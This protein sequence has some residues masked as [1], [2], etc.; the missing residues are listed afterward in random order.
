[1]MYLTE[2]SLKRVIWNQYLFKMTALP[3]LFTSLILTQLAAFALSLDGTGGTSIGFDTITVRITHFSGDLIF[4]FT[5]MWA[6]IAGIMLTIRQYRNAD[7]FFVTNR[8]TQHLSTIALLLTASLYAG[9]V[10]PLLGNLLRLVIYWS[11]P[12]NVMTAIAPRPGELLL[13]LLITTWYAALLSCFGYLTGMLAQLNRVFIILIPALIIGSVYAQDSGGILTA[14][15]RFYAAE[16]SILL[17]SVKAALT[18]AIVYP[19]TM[20]I[21]SSLEVRR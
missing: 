13:N 5:L 3:G 8:W 21:T 2:P 7:F 20:L 14:A 11:H 6:Y 17:L 16:T 18:L 1:M 4:Y 12:D 10:T 9:I 19:F 15:I